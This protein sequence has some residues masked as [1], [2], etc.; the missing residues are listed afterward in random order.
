MAVSIIALLSGSVSGQ[1]VPNITEWHDTMHNAM[2]PLLDAME[3]H[4]VATFTQ[5]RGV[6]H[7]HEK[8][9]RFTLNSF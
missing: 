8:Y 7:L 2:K 6:P 5:E 9:G 3:P 4:K 1:Q